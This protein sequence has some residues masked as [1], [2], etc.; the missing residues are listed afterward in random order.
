MFQALGDPTR[1]Q[2][3]DRLNVRNGQNLGELCAGLDLTRQTI[4]K[5]LEIL[6][7]A[8]LVVV[9]RRGRERLHHLN[10]APIHDISER[11]LSRYDRH[12]ADALADLARAL[13]APTME[14]TTFVYRSHIKA[15]PERLW[16]GLTSPEFTTRYWA[17]EFVT[18]WRPGSPMTWIHH[19]QTISDPEQIVLE[20]DP[21]RRLSYTWVTFTPELAAQFGMAD[22]VVVRLTAERRSKVTFD[23]VDHG[24]V[25][26]LTVTHDDFD[27]DAI[28]LQMV[29]HGWP[30][31]ISDLKTLLETGDTLVP[32]P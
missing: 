29:S 12:R 7:G 23:L 26:E 8:G 18:D 2:L 10:A 16:Q 13:E 14:S 15:T 25:V 21:Y 27:P 32:A 1:R 17:T 20:S 5:H 9:T 31:L 30:H 6:E 19:G 11:W 22:E 4:T 3:L 28:G 24:G